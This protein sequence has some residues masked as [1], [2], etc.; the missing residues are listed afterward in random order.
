MTDNDSQGKWKGPSG[1]D[2]WDANSC[3]C[4]LAV[5]LGQD[6]LVNGRCKNPCPSYTVDKCGITTAD[7]TGGWAES[8][9]VHI[10]P[11]G[12]GT[13]DDGNRP[14]FRVLPTEMVFRVVPAEM[15]VCLQH[16][17][18]FLPRRQGIPWGAVRQ[19][20]LH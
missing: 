15:V 12:F 19:Q 18:L 14:M 4:Q 6:T 20:G 10:N 3:G 13:W 16:I 7:L 2:S 1:A 17:R 5:A 9:R 8:V 11:N